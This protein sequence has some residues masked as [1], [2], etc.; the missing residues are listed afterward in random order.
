MG[1]V[2]STWIEV[3]G[4][5][6]DPTTPPPHPD[7]FNAQGGC[8]HVHSFRTVVSI[9]HFLPNSS[10]LRSMCCK[11]RRILAKRDRRCSPIF[12]AKYLVAW[13]LDNDAGPEIRTKKAGSEVLWSRHTALES[14]SPPNADNDNHENN[15]NDKLR[16]FLNLPEPQQA[17]THY[18]HLRKGLLQGLSVCAGTHRHAFPGMWGSWLQGFGLGPA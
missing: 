14:L 16:V 5:G 6:Y 17:Q 7:E 10:C 15:D 8:Q 18:N 3:L 2:R 9:Q 13:Q 4:L 11:S 1:F 12:S